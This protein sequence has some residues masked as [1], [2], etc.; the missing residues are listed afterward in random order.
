[1]MDSEAFVV[2]ANL[3]D[4][5]IA[6]AFRCEHKELKKIAMLVCG[7][8]NEFRSKFREFSATSCVIILVLGVEN[9]VDEQFNEMKQKILSVTAGKS[10]L[11]QNLPDKTECSF[12]SQTVI[13]V[14]R[15]RPCSSSESHSLVDLCTPEDCIENEIP[16]SLNL[17]NPTS[18]N[19]EQKKG[20]TVLSANSSLAKNSKRAPKKKKTVLFSEKYSPLLEVPVTANSTEQ[21]NKQDQSPN[22]K[23][24]QNCFQLKKALCGFKR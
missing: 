23:Q 8:K 16:C 4:E 21:S 6:S 20:I 24:K 10:A 9:L 15:H 1:M 18:K 2:W 3:F 14:K 13:D 7:L 5:N 22:K 19:N 17:L 11:F 12:E